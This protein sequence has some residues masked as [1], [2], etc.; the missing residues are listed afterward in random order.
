MPKQ[1]TDTAA[2]KPSPR[3][4]TPPSPP[5]WP[6]TGRLAHRHL[7][8][9]L[10][11]G[12][13]DRL[14]RPVADWTAVERRALPPSKRRRELRAFSAAVEDIAAR[15]L[16]V[17]P[18][19]LLEEAALDPPPASPGRLAATPLL[20]RAQAGQAAVEA[21]RGLAAVYAAAGDRLPAGEHGGPKLAAPLTF[22]LRALLEI[23]RRHRPGVEPKPG[24][25]VGSFGALA[26]DLF[27]A[28]PCSYDGR[29]IS[30]AL[31]AVLKH[32]AAPR[33]AGEA[34]AA[35]VPAEPRL[36][37]VRIIGLNSALSRALQAA[38]AAEGVEVELHDWAP[39]APRAKP[40]EACDLLVM[41]PEEQ[42]ALR[43]RDIRHAPLMSQEAMMRSLVLDPLRELDRLERAAKPRRVV[44][45]MPA[46]PDAPQ[47]AV[48]AWAPL[49]AARAALAALVQMHARAPGWEGSAVVAMQIGWGARAEDAGLPNIPSSNAEIAATL[50]DSLARLGPEHSGAALDLHGSRLPVLMTWPHPEVVRAAAQRPAA[51]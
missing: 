3:R 8:A 48:Q 10:A 6:D 14:L 17:G 11:A 51:P 31:T 41:I 37:V 36:A 24:R 7:A 33:P 15:M 4:R 49:Y 45:L 39:A 30:A 19:P 13:L 21:L 26:H 47:Y 18:G 9:P 23:W 50:L 29:H 46:V 28:P 1:T 5:D 12:D 20:A 40:S 34:S 43:P 25:A 2:R 32:D 27:G 35:V 44:I 16:A 22:G 42:E 38:L